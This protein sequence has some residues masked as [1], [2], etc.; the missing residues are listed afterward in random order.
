MSLADDIKHAINQYVELLANGT[1]EAIAEL[2]SDDGTVEDPIGGEVHRGHDAILR[3]Y[4]PLESLARKSELVSMFVTS[5]E[6][7]FQMNVMLDSGGHRVLFNSVD[8]MVFDDDAKITSMR[9]YWGP[10][11][12]Q[13]LSASEPVS[14]E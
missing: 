11:N 4:T 12:V 2:F 9:A 5:N 6:A 7:A 13:Q 14:T 10:E 8:V 1:A 3:M